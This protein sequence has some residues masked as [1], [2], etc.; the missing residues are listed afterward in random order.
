MYIHN[1]SQHHAP[2]HAGLWRSVWDPQ[3]NTDIRFIPPITETSFVC[4]SF[5]Y[6]LPVFVCRPWAQIFQQAGPYWISSDIFDPEMVQVLE[7][8]WQFHVKGQ[9]LGTRIN[10]LEGL[11]MRKKCGTS[12][13][14]QGL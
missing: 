11:E 8:V 7:E 6:K 10:R 2:H 9:L 1:S 13:S 5:G 14:V 12:V 4:F 3:Q